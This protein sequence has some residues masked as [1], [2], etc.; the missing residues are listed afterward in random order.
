M[1]L[2]ERQK[3]V[4][5]ETGFKFPNHEIFAQIFYDELEAIKDDNKR[6]N[7]RNNKKRDETNTMQ[8]IAF[9][10]TDYN[11]DFDLN[12]IKISDFLVSHRYDFALLYI[13]LWESG[14]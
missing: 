9:W 10:I 3:I 1:Y 4:E 13:L 7:R 12:E 5:K 8:R 2:H 11:S 14:V 6:N